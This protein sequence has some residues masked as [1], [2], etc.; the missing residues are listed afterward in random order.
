VAINSP[1]S[2]N[3]GMVNSAVKV[4]IREASADLTHHQH[5]LHL[6]LQVA[7]GFN[8]LFGAG[9]FRIMCMH[10]HAVRRHD[11]ILP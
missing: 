3:S 5:Y 4:A 8:W 2:H 1:H 7:A 9:R 6:I 11:C 10:V